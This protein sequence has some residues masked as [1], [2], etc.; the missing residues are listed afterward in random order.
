MTLIGVLSDTHLREYDAGLEGRLTQA[1]AG[2]DMILHAGDLTNMQVLDMLECEEVLAVCGNM[3]DHMVANA[4]PPKRVIEVG[5]MSIGLIHGWGSPHGLENRIRSEFDQVDCIVYG[6]S[7]RPANHLKD[8]VLF[9]NPGSA[10]SSYRGSGTVGLLEV[11][12][13][14]RGKILELR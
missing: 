11:G 3:D 1:F 5:G 6:H 7:H 13:H 12:K 8:G 10:S 2:V 9:F 4:L 14:I